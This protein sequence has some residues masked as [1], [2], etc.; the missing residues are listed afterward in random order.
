MKPVILYLD[1]DHLQHV[2]LNKKMADHFSIIPSLNPTMA[3][4]QLRDAPVDAIVSD[5]HLPAVNGFK[6]HEMLRHN[7]LDTIPFFIFSNDCTDNSRVNGLKMG[8]EDCL[9]SVMSA[10]EIYQRVINR[11]NKTIYSFHHISINIK[12]LQAFREGEY[13]DL[14][15]TEFKILFL[16][17]KNQDQ[18]LTREKIKNFIWPHMVVMDKTI[19]THLSNLRLKIED[20]SL[21][22]I[23]I[24]GEGIK[25]FLDKT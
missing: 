4:D 23:S 21:K 25:L 14:T 3:I 13:L 18:I 10:E 20:N 17:I 19:N 6:F 1:A 12:K 16:L 8:A 7:N 24:K 2:A 15:Q 22:I 5:L 11:I 9:T